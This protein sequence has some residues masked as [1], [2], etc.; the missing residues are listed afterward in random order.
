MMGHLFILVARY[1]PGAAL[2]A[3]FVLLF[4]RPAAQVAGG[5]P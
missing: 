1:W 4:V 5:A 3:A 2:A